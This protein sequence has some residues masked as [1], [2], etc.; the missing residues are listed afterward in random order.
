[1]KIHLPIVDSEPTSPIEEPD[2]VFRADGEVVLLVE[3]EPEVQRMAE[4]ILSK[5]GF[6]VLKTDLGSEALGLCAD[7]DQRI[8]LLLTDVI[9]PE[10]LGTELVERARRLRS[11]LRVLYMSGY[12]HDVLAPQALTDSGESGFI[13]KPFSSTA[14]LGA[15]GELLG[16]RAESEG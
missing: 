8:D 3:D 4:R 11:D 9:M 6:L 16:D 1:M 15:I 14:L 13:E 12:S 7:P 5:G 2:P 10:M